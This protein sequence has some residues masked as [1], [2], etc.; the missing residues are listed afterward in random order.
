MFVNKNYSLLYVG[1]KYSFSA[2]TILYNNRFYNGILFLI[3]L[4]VL[5]VLEAILDI[6]IV[7]KRFDI[8]KLIY[9]N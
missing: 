2:A 6:L 7:F 8:F 3:M 9:V 4:S 1:D 5:L